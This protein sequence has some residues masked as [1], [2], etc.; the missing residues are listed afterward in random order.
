[1]PFIISLHPFPSH[2]WLLSFIS[3]FSF[4]SP[5]LSSRFFFFL[6]FF[7]ACFHLLSHWFS[8]KHP[9]PCHSPVP[10]SHF[11]SVWDFHPCFNH[12]QPAL[13]C[14]LSAVSKQW[15]F[16]SCFHY[17]HNLIF[18]TFLSFILS[19]GQPRELCFPNPIQSNPIWSRR[20]IEADNFWVT[21]RIDSPRCQTKQCGKCCAFSLGPTI[22]SKIC[23]A[24]P[25]WF[26]TFPSDGSWSGPS[27]VWSTIID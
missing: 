5:L 17:P 13:H 16:S 19:F 12:S 1:M 7:H 14:F 18:S 25:C 8:S 9:L 20:P 3:F 2:L 26:P 24:L 23:L 21:I 27:C 11:E 22:E 6:S 10:T 15:F 4:F